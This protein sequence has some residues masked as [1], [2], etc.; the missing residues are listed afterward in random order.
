MQER[1]RDVVKHRAEQLVLSAADAFC[2]RCQQ[3]PGAESRQRTHKAEDAE[4]RVRHALGIDVDL[5]T[6]HHEVDL[7]EYTDI[8]EGKV[9]E[10]RVAA[11]PPGSAAQMPVSI[12]FVYRMT[13]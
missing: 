10:R 9:E 3:I 8:R 11:A 4:L 13:S 2:K 6:Q 5:H 1:D 7:P 12:G